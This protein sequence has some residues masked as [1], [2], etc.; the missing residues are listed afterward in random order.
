MGFRVK[1][2]PGVRVGVS[3]RGVGASIGPRVARA[4]VGPGGLGASTGLGPV[5]AYAGL[6]VGRRGVSD[7]GSLAE[8]ERALRRE[9]RL[10]EIDHVQRVHDQFTRHLVAHRE[11]FRPVQ[12]PV[13]SAATVDVEARVTD[14]RR[15]AVAGISPLRV[16]QRRRAREKAE[17]EARKRAHTDQED[18]RRVAADQQ[19]LAD[20][21]WDR[22][23]ANDPE[24]VLATI[25]EAFADNDVPAAPIDCDG[26]AVTLLMRFPSIDGVVPKRAPD[27][28][29]TGRPTVREYSLTERNGLHVGAMLSHANATVAEAF[30]VAPSIRHATLLVVGVDG[31]D[32]TP[33]YCAGVVREDFAR[34]AWERDSVAVPGPGHLIN[35]R[36]RTRELAPL[37]LGHEPHLRDAVFRVAE[38]LGLHVNAE[39]GIAAASAR[40]AEASAP[41]LASQD[42][43]PAG[44]PSVDAPDL[45]LPNRVTQ[46]WLDEHV[47]ALSDAAYEHLLTLLERRGWTAD[48]VAERVASRRTH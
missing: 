29:P 48:E 46:A 44:S 42:T 25:E 38:H 39:A 34:G 4:H 10:I 16:Q 13:V 47:P 22:L 31:T 35:V 7:R 2:A 26:D 30:A 17:A 27:R 5:G 36:G 37:M 18:A 40:D 11:A 23:L 6:G 21:A 24:T 3:S 43:A 8:Y 20:D 32:L 33:L 28:T 15:K 14:A 1:I 9:Q 45:A 41:T 19:A 12:R